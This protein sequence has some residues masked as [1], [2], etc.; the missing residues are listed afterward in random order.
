[1]TTCNAASLPYARSVSASAAAAGAASAARPGR[2]AVAGCP[3]SP[4]VLGAGAAGTAHRTPHSS[5]RAASPVSPVRAGRLTAVR[6]HWGLGSAVWSAVWG[7]E[8]GRVGSVAGAALSLGGPAAASLAGKAGAVAAAAGAASGARP[9][10]GSV[11]VTQLVSA[12]V[13]G[14]IMAAERQCSKHQSNTIPFLVNSKSGKRGESREQSVSDA[15]VLAFS[16][17]VDRHGPVMVDGVS[18]PDST[19]YSVTD[20]T[21][22]SGSRSTQSGRGF[23]AAFGRRFAPLFDT[24]GAAVSPRYSTRDWHGTVMTI[25]RA[26]TALVRKEA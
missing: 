26:P 3:V 16:T 8:S 10:S 13:I 21:R 23:D 7:A 15:S 14:W 4:R 20:S 25:R 18:G 6:P 5:L 12:F 19:A 9:N 17:L 2:D 1:M 24:A 11:R 22:C